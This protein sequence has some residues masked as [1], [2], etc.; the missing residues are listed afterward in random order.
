MAIDVG[1]QI[2]FFRTQKN[3]SVNKLATL[4][5]ISQSYLRDIEL[6][7]K[8]PTIE[9]LTYICDALGLS[10]ADFFNDSTQDTITNDPLLTK[11]YQLN[12][13]QRAALLNFLN[14]MQE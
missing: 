11:I 13:K 4:S 5:G 2:T 8:N 10:L 3:I 12:P 6:G 7:N 1:K 9:I 14:E